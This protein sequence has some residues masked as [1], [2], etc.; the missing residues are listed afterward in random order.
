MFSPNDLII[1]MKLINKTNKRM[2]DCLIFAGGGSIFAIHC[3]CDVISKNLT[4]SS[5]P[6]KQTN[7]QRKKERKKERKKQ[8]NKQTNKPNK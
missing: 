2:N 4:F 7:N 6:K 3:E 1:T 8:T 5:Q